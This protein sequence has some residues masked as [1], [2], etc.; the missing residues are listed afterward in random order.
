MRKRKRGG[1]TSMYHAISSGLFSLLQV[2]LPATRRTTVSMTRPALVAC[3]STQVTR[4]R[5]SQSIY[6]PNKGTL[7]DLPLQTIKM[8][9]AANIK[10]QGQAPHPAPARCVSGMRH[11]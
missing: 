3:A 6:L 1:R 4:A 11:S 5:Q 7:M 8:R 10:V 2:S 9:N